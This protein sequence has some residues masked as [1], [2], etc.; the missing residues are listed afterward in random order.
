MITDAGW[1]LVDDSDNVAL[2]EWV[3]QFNSLASNSD[4]FE[5]WEQLNTVLPNGYALVGSFQFSGEPANG[6]YFVAGLAL[7][8]GELLGDPWV[9]RFEYFSSPLFSTF[10]GNFP[11]PDVNGQ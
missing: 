7:N 10:Y 9:A 2:A 5:I 4:L 6:D 11:V 8:E 1:A 3:E